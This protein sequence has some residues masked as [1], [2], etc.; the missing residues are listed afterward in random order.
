M[1]LLTKINNSQ[2]YVNMEIN[3]DFDKIDQLYGY[4]IPQN[5]IY[6]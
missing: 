1:L 5:K 2:S 4:D 3:E 6:C